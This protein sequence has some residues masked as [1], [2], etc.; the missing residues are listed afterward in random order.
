MVN[1]GASG[2]IP[3]LAQKV[4]PSVQMI[5]R[6]TDPNIYN[7]ISQAASQQRNQQIKIP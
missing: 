2:Q 5:H 7:Q 3:P 6:D 1:F 4:V